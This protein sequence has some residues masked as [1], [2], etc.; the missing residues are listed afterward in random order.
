M[1]NM[2]LY[3]VQQ[4]HERDWIIFQILWWFWFIILQTFCIRIF[5]L[6]QSVLDI[7]EIADF[8]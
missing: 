2:T 3:D 8:Y 5:E 1:V 4:K 7:A 6:F